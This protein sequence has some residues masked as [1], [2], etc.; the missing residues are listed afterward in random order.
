[1][2]Q[3]THAQDGLNHTAGLIVNEPPAISLVRTIPMIA[4][5]ERLS[6][7]E[8]KAAFAKLAQQG[9]LM[10]RRLFAG[11]HDHDASIDLKDAQG[12]T[13]LRLSVARNGAQK[14]E[15]LDAPGKIVRTIGP[16]G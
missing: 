12:H 14:I 7:A 11:L 10:R 2:T 16:T 6:P 4:R 5:A 13:R 9:Y 15:F 8:R 1:V 3:I